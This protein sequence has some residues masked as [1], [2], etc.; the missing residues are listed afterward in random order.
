MLLQ[1]K[2]FNPSS[3]VI[4]YNLHLIY[5]KICQMCALKSQLQLKY[6]SENLEKHL[7]KVIYNPLWDSQTI[8]NRDTQVSNRREQ[9]ICN[10]E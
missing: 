7:Y 4:N 1:R 3:V 9:V 10:Y 8:I 6:A 5:F 2:Y